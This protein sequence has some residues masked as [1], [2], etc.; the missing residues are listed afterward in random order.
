MKFI[1]PINI[2]DASL[3]STNVSNDVGVLLW[4][5]GQTIAQDDVRRYEAVGK[6]WIVRAL[7]SH[8][9][10][11][12]NAPTGLDNDPNW[13][14]MYDANPWRMLDN[15]S[16][17]TSVRS[18]LIDTTIAA[19]DDD[20]A[21]N[22]VYGLNLFGES[23]TFTMYNINDEV[24]YTG[25]E[26]LIRDDNRL[27]WEDWLFAPVL[28]KADVILTDLPINYLA[29][30]RIEVVNQFGDA[31]CGMFGA[32]YLHDAGGSELGAKRG[33]RDFS[34]KEADEFGNYT[35]TTRK[36]SKTITITSMVENSDLD[37]LLNT[38]DDLSSQGVVYMGT[39]PY[40][41]TWVF[42]FYKDAFATM[43]FD[44][45]SRMNFD[46]EELS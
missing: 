30:L 44:S 34:R 14:Y 16:T 39:D 25:T 17:S 36:K 42:G 41:E 32:G 19:A 22:S 18:L 11:L 5:V 2:N 10:A 26:S 8:T 21:V 3:I 33:L 27:D 37:P 40:R 45:H 20:I 23:V 24:V 43:V 15:S 1:Q 29:K 4:T 13:V 28:R 31:Q 46:I 7:Q 12:N 38:L 35:I 9:S 6:H